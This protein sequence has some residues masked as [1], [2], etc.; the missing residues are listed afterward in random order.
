ML[1]LEH[2]CALRQ[3]AGKGERLEDGVHAAAEG[4]HPLVGAGVG[5]RYSSTSLQI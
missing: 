3:P 1:A 4:D 5:A 2:C